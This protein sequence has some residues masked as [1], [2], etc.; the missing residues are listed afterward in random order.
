MAKL[1]ANSTIDGEPIASMGAVTLYIQSIL[2]GLVSV[3]KTNRLQVGSGTAIT[4][5]EIV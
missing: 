3:F 2:A 4:K 5:I 1:K